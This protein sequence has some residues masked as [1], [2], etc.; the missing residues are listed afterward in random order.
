MPLDFP[1]GPFPSRP[2]AGGHGA[3]EPP[4]LP[5]VAL[6]DPARGSTRETAAGPS[7]PLSPCPGALPQPRLP[8][9][10]PR[11][12]G[13]HRNPPA[14]PP[15][16]HAASSGEW[17]NA[18]APGP[19][20]TRQ[21]ARA[22]PVGPARQTPPSAGCRGHGHCSSCCAGK[23]GRGGGEPASPEQ[24]SPAQPGPAQTQ[25]SHVAGP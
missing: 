18:P 15:A 6:R 7:T 11:S 13:T 8:A 1:R 3:R 20:S 23:H 5:H 16:P 24:P 12:W 19:L 14:A 10:E 22:C 21:D 9:G 2:P 25:P 4:G 17:R